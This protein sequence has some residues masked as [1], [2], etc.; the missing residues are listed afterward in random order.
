ME[1]QRVRDEIL[2]RLSF[3]DRMR[4]VDELTATVQELALNGLRSRHPSASE[5][6]IFFRF[7]E[8]VLGPALAERVRTYRHAKVRQAEV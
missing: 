3:A 7:S 4:M 2:R 1:A 8:M 6:E 5:E